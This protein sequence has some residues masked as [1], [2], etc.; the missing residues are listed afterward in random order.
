MS[1]QVTPG[2]DAAD[3][4]REQRTV[5]PT[6]IRYAATD[7][8]RHGPHSAMARKVGAGCE[9]EEPAD[10]AA[11][12]PT[13]SSGG[14][15]SVWGSA[16]RAAGQPCRVNCASRARPRTQL[17]RPPRR[18]RR[19]QWL[20]RFERTRAATPS[21]RSIRWRY[22]PPGKSN[23]SMRRVELELAVATSRGGGVIRARRPARGHPREQPRPVG[24]NTVRCDDETVSPLP[25]RSTPVSPIKS[26][27]MGRTPADRG[28]ASSGSGFGHRGR[29]QDQRDYYRG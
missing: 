12:P 7:G 6:E 27:E 10:R 28:A 21:G 15:S 29:H 1:S 2:R 23:G 16:S 19:Y 8:C 5:E 25:A 26:R 3:R 20:T 17:G 4:E 9:S 14:R 24:L 13:R 18:R 11:R 22:G